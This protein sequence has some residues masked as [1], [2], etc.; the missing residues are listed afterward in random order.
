MTTMPVSGLRPESGE[1]AQPTSGAR[2]RLRRRVAA[3]AAVGIAAAFVV[4]TSAAHAADGPAPEPLEYRVLQKVHTDAVSTFLDE[5]TFVLGTKADVP[6]GNGT[7]L[8]TAR[9]LFHVDDAARQ[10]IPAGYE[11]VGPAGDTVW[12]APESNPSGGDGYTQLW[13]G[14]STES[15]PAGGV[16][17]NSTTFRLAAVEAPD[18]GQVELWRGSGNGLTR[19][20]SSDEG[21][22][23]FTIGRT[24]Q[25]ANWA[26]TQPGTYRL[27]IEGSAVVGGEPVSDTEVYT[28]VVGDLPGTVE[29]STTLTA[30]STETMQGS[31]VTLSAEVG[32]AG[33]EGYVEFR[34]GDTALGH[35]EASDDGRAELTVSDLGV[36]TRSL[37]A[38][39]VPAVANF[40][41]GST[42]DAVE[43]RVLD[44][45]GVE[46]GVVG[47]D[48]AY[49][50][51]DTLTAT[52]V[53][54]TLEGNQV[55]RWLARTQGFDSTM[56]AQST[57]AAT[58]ARELDALADDTEISVTVYDPDTRTTV[59]ETPWTPVVV[60]NQGATPVV[61]VTEGHPDPMLP[62]DVIEYTVSGRELGEG[63][64]ITWG[65]LHYGGYFGSQIYPGEW[66]ATYPDENTVRLR[67]K[68][69]PEE[70]ETF[71]APLTANVVKDEVT[72]ARSDFHTVST[73]HRELNVSGHR[74]LYREGGAV[75]L[76]AAVYPERAG[77]DLTYTWHF[78]RGETTE[79]WGTEQQESGAVTGPD[80][81]VAEHDGGTL[82]LDL[83][84]NGVLAQQS[85]L[86][87]VNVTDDLTSQILEFGTL[88]DHYHQGSPV[89]LGLTV[90]PAP[91]AGDDL[92]WQWRWPGSD[93]WTRMA[94][95]EDNLYEVAAE[96]V[97]D[98]LEIRA[99][100]TY[101]AAATSPMVS[102]TRTVYV[103]DH[104][105]PARQTVTVSG[106]TEY[107][108][109]ATVALAA[110]VEPGTVLTDY[111]WE[112]KAAGQ[113]EFT[114]LDGETGRE[115][116]FEAAAG[117]D[118]AQYRAAPVTP[119]GRVGYG[120][121]EPV[122]LVVTEAPPEEP[123]TEEP[124]TE[125]PGTEDPGTE[126]PG[127][128]QP[129]AE[130]PGAEDPGA[131]D[132]GAEDPGAE[133][134]EGPGGDEPA[135]ADPTDD[136]SATGGSASGPSGEQGTGTAS[137][138]AATGASR[139]VAVTGAALAMALGGV[140]LIAVRR[141]AF[142]K[143]QPTRA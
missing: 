73:G 138:L 129:G 101:A 22:D 18:G 37:T 64:S 92:E 4:P 142:R 5:G 120:P 25:H 24:H 48:D 29:T 8:D 123:G 115:L 133:E 46:F 89:S 58:F 106:E 83:Y 30:S 60:E 105:A 76:D 109:G 20:W 104:G 135:E 140:L 119:A 103:D 113:D 91:L 98:G 134:P 132:P 110:D 90:D 53:G 68:S 100:L 85:S 51:G 16:D 50:V 139:L 112:R 1:R 59:A 78:S 65:F 13:P 97:M 10:T 111:R 9:T 28:F 107:V 141:R 99:V 56:V 118:G 124:G 39:F 80:L 38:V 55:F 54:A 125:D 49:Q 137:L 131:E 94:G 26:F 66:E 71:P 2:V 121:S 77:D 74:N 57:T 35:T 116:R 87:T 127:A 44:G 62:G 31:P 19:M 43:V 93:E 36:G 136:D 11:F 42:S 72:V 128:E 143:D 117:D 21:I 52:V 12:I 3:A 41:T 108:E 126:E 82:R 81:D 32:P 95:V 86:F 17:G 63:E 67:S 33:V 70:T 27:T 75:T 15:V 96:Q 88:S 7:R 122:A 84:N 61:E 6:E 69:N 45:S 102:E 47:I 34:D 14:F 114:V 130:E 23:E 79:V 40:T